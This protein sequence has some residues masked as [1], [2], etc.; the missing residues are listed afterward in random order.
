[1]CRKNTYQI[2]KNINIDFIV[3]GLKW[4]FFFLAFLP[5]NVYYVHS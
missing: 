5:K 2:M 1:M 3:D 4:L